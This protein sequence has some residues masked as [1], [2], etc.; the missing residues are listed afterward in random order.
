MKIATLNFK[1]ANIEVLDVPTPI[2]KPADILVATHRSLISAGTEGYII[3]MAQKGPLGKALDRPD[4]AM[5]VI[6]K[7]LMEGF[8]GTAKIVNNLINTPLPLG[9]SLS[10]E[11]LE[12]GR[13]ADR[14]RPGE[15]VACAGIGIANHAEHVVIPKTMGAKLPPNVSYEDAAFGTLGAIALHGVRLAR[16]V[17]GETCVVLGLGLLGLITIQILQA[18]GCTVIGFDVDSTKLT[19][20]KEFGIEACGLLGHDDPKRLV[21]SCTDGRGADTVIITA[22]AKSSKPLH[23]AAEL[24]RLKGRIVSVGLTGLNVPRRIFFEKELQLEVSRAYGPGAYDVAYERKGHDYPQAYV[25]WTQGRNLQ[26]FIDLIAKNKVRVDNLITHRFDLADAKE[27]YKLIMGERKEPYIGILFTYSSVKPRSASITLQ[28]KASPP[29]K[30]DLRFG[31][32]GAG[33]W[34]QAILLPYLR[35]EQDVTIGAVAT[36]SGLSARHVGDKY[37]A[38]LATTEYNDILACSDIG[39]IVIATRHNT[40]AGLVFDA[41]KAQKNIFVE[42][43]LA[44]STEELDSIISLYPSYTK[45][46]TVGFNRRYSPLCRTFKRHLEKRKRPLLLVYRFITPMVTQGHESEWVHDPQSG[47]SRIIG[48]VCHMVDTAAYL[49][50]SPARKIYASSMAA[51][52]TNIPNYDNVHATI[53]YV[54]GSVATLIYVADSDTSVPQERIELFWEQSYGLIDN[55]KQGMFSRGGKRKKYRGFSQQ[56][57]WKEEVQH[58]VAALRKNSDIGVI[59]FESLVETTRCTL[60]IHNSIEKG[61]IF[62]LSDVKK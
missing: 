32:I 41:M 24:S 29:Q 17:L 26:A 56:K 54:D 5:Q 50:G 42:K 4:L 62:D 11:V 34:A 58:F 36:A 27:A 53:S 51:D 48:E 33:R 55:F 9:Y 21:S 20:A 18:S 25:P 6:R 39:S 35:K 16:P 49:I 57:G 47:G 13:E 60:A 46:L 3:R 8:W 44:T 1:N 19:K 7:A 43:P 10:G 12:V 22:H 23:L 61:I 38:T 15:R 14:F 40:H 28:S 52:A 2:L 59:P 31:I 30:V 37:N 45:C